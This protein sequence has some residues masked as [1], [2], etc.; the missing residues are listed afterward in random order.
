MGR[1]SADIVKHFRKSGD[2]VRKLVGNAQYLDVALHYIQ[3]KIII[4]KLIF[5]L[6]T[7]LL[8]FKALCFIIAGL[9]TIPE[10]EKKGILVVYS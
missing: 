3:L 7:C 10:K 4:V 1:M 6:N 2:I 5:P 8:Y 9:Q